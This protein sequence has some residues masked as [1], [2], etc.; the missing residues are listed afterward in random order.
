MTD[1]H[2]RWWCDP[3]ER[4]QQFDATPVENH[5]LI[6]RDAVPIGYMRWKTLSLKDLAAV[7]LT[8]I[9]E[10]SVDIDIFIGSSGEAGRARR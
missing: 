8:G 7:G 9:P 2:S 5:A 10:N 3:E 1:L 4:L 6:A